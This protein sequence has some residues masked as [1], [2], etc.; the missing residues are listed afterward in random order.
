M[1]VLKDMSRDKKEEIRKLG[2]ANVLHLNCKVLRKTMCKWIIDHLD[3]ET[4]TLSIHR[5]KTRLTPTHVEY[6][7]GFKDNGIKVMEAELID[8][9][10][11]SVDFLRLSSKTTTSLA[12][13]LRKL[14]PTDPMFKPTFVM[15]LMTAF[16][17]PTANKT[18]KRSWLHL[19]HNEEMFSSWNWAQLIFDSTIAA[20]AQFKA[21]DSPST[22]GGCTMFLMVRYSIFLVVYLIHDI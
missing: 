9:D 4:C 8:R 22:L 2:F 11:C 17:A 21:S 19:V 12:T 7:L 15:F 14:T 18:P 13:D 10:S 1:D 5:N 16:A 20:V 3:P 6:L